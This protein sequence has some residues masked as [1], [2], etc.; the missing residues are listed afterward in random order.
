MGTHS[1]EQLSSRR[2]LSGWRSQGRDSCGLWEPAQTGT[3]VRRPAPPPDLDALMP[4]GFL[5]RTKGRCFVVKSWTPQVEVL[6]YRAT[7]AFVTHCGWNSTLEGVTAG[8]PLL[9]WPLYAE[10]QLNKVHIVWRR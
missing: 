2:S 7:G 6:R 4:D 8:L 9:C 1:D 10:Q 5:E 3:E